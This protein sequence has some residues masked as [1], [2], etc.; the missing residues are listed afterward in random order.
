MLNS[1]LDVAKSV[2]TCTTIWFTILTRVY[3]DKYND[4]KVELAGPSYLIRLKH[5]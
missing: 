3:R 2:N 1:S 5:S 4:S